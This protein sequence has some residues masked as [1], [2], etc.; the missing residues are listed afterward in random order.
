MDSSHLLRCSILASFADYLVITWRSCA[1]NC[2]SVHCYLA[3]PLSSDTKTCII[4]HH[5][6][7]FIKLRKQGVSPL[8]KYSASVSTEKLPGSLRCVE[9]YGDISM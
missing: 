9:P 7:H 3:E 4:L 1:G 6:R 2:G 5:H 8:H